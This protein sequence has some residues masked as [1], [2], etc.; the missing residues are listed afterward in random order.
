[1]SLYQAWTTL[2]PERGRRR[3]ARRCVR[4]SRI[5]EINDYFPPELEQ[6][7]N[8]RNGFKSI[9]HKLQ[10]W[11]CV[12]CRNKSL[13]V[14]QHDDAIS[15]VVRSG[16]LSTATAAPIGR[17]SARVFR[18]PIGKFQVFPYFAPFVTVFFRFAWPVIDLSEGV[19]GVANYVC[20][21][22]EGFRHGLHPLLCILEPLSA[23]RVPTHP[24][25]SHVVVLT[26][27]S[28]LAKLF[29]DNP[30]TPIVKCSTGRR[31]VL[32]ILGESHQRNPSR[33]ATRSPR[34][35]ERR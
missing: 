3:A 16:S 26:L 27:P 28:P 32:C 23:K 5:V 10:L 20:Y 13:V 8:D 2:R 14:V 7:I 25:N 22:I 31:K 21:Y 35:S 34:E 30:T 18:D 6:E 11:R 4:C 19:F 29:Q 12:P 9:T 33:A 1:M 24:E 15:A 17:R